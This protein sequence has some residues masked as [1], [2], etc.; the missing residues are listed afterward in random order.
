LIV[1][2]DQPQL[3][4]TIVE[5]VL[6]A[7]VDGGGRDI[8]VPSYEHRRGHPIILPRWMW[9]EV[10]DLPPG[11]TLRTAINRHAATI[12]YL[13][14]DTPTVLADVDTPEQYRTALSEQAP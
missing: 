6:Q 5:Q 1:L 14:V 8:V 12:R 10:L 13:V 7:F 4:Q 3:R 2:A 11:E 9:Q